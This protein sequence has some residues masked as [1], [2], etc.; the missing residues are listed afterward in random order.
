M[1]LL[2]YDLLKYLKVL[3]RYGEL[4]ILFLQWAHCHLGKYV[5][6]LLDIEHHLRIGLDNALYVEADAPLLFSLLGGVFWHELEDVL[7]LT[8]KKV[9]VAVDV[10]VVYA[11]EVADA[12]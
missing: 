12:F 6:W 5:A 1:L 2:L 8:Q 10:I 4:K 3:I 9:G 7:E 11:V